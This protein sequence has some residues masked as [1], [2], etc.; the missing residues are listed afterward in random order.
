[1]RYEDMDCGI[2]VDTPKG[3]GVVR[4]Y[5]AKVPE[6]RKLFDGLGSTSVPNPLKAIIDL[7]TGGTIM[8]AI[9][10]LSKLGGR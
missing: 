5:D 10:K 3:P 9:R 1:M 2:R 6:L 4:S 7:D 8:V